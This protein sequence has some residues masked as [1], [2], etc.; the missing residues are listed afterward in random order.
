MLV[1]ANEDVVVLLPTRASAAT[2][3]CWSSGAAVGD[4]AV[5]STEGSA[6]EGAIGAGVESVISRGRQLPRFTHDSDPVRQRA[7][8]SHIAGMLPCGK[9]EQ[10]AAKT[11][12]AVRAPFN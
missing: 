3:T 9:P 11:L 4:L 5:I 2:A 10:I 7:H 1:V 8:A 12:E 6:M